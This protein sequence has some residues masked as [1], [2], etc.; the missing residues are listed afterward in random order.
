MNVTPVEDGITAEMEKTDFLANICRQQFST[1][2]K[3]ITEIK[4]CRPCVSESLDRNAELG[5]TGG[6]QK[7]CLFNVD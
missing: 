5:S 3:L 7:T 6:M 1:T 4:T 2:D